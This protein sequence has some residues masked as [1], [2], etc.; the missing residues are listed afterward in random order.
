MEA[1]EPTPRR[2]PQFS[3]LTLLLMTAL[4]ALGAVVVAQQQEVAE[5]RAEVQPMRDEVQRIG[6]EV[7]GLDVIDPEKL[8]L[9]AMPLNGPDEWSYRVHLPA[10]RRYVV[11]YQVNKLPL[12]G[13]PPELAPMP[14]GDEIGSLLSGGYCT[15][16][17]GEHVVRLALERTNEGKWKVVFMTSQ[18]GAAQPSSITEAELPLNLATDWPEVRKSALATGGVSGKQQERTLRNG[19]TD[20]VILL[21]HRSFERGAGQSSADAPDGAMMWLQAA[22]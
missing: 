3:L 15:F 18:A 6:N 14:V 5:M 8:Y 4:V 22:P 20:Q 1:N 2:L 10:G 17:P 12:R 9:I 19:A 7:A 16:E 11:A 21:N 13:A